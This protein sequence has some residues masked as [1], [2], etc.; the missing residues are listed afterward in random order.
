MSL[1]GYYDDIDSLARRGE[2][3]RGE[4][5]R[6]WLLSDLDTWHKCGGCDKATDANHPEAGDPQE[7]QC[8]ACSGFGYYD[9]DDSPPC[10]HCGGNG[11]RMLVRECG[12]KGCSADAIE[13]SAFSFCAAHRTS[14]LRRVA[15]TPKGAFGFTVTLRPSPDEIPF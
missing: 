9:D 3:C 13:A 5:C 14:D 15:A 8:G 4:D 6:G 2:L 10:G 11:Y 7:E 1:Q 12:F